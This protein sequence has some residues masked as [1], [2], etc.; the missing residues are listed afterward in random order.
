[1][2]F[3]RVLSRSGHP[4]L[5]FLWLR[6]DDWHGLGVEGRDG[7]GN[8]SFSEELVNGTCPMVME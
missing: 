6:K 1:M 2:K 7:S 8:T 4:L 3:Q 5:E